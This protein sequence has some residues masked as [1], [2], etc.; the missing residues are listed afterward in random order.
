MI[1]ALTPF[2]DAALRM[3]TVVFTVLL[4]PVGLYWIVSLLGIFSLDWI[5]GVDGAIDGASEGL[6]EAAGEALAEGAGEALGEAAGEAIAESVGEAAHEAAGEVVVDS[7]DMHQ[8]PS[9]I[10]HLSFGDVPRSFSWSLVIGF[11]WL[12]SLLG[13]VYIPGFDDAASSGLVTGGAI[14][15]VLGVVS[16]GLAVVATSLA[17]RPV[18]KAMRA[19]QGARR[20]QLVGRTCTVRTSRVDTTFGQ[21]EVDDGSMIIDVRTTDP[22]AELVHGARALIFNYD[23]D[24]E[25]FLVAPLDRELVP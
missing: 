24:R 18:N 8:R 12:F 16:L 19:G 11:A 1:D 3:P 15:A 23:G 10:E 6:A 20:H 25:V 14:A 9:F 4:V 7:L 13:S 17:L 5:D 22:T 21:A 2:V